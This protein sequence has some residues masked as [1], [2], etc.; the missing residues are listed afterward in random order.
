MVLFQ[1]KKNQWL[2]VSL[3]GV[4]EENGII[5]KILEIKCPH[6]CVNK[7][8]IDIENK[9]SNVPYLHFKENDILLNESHQ[10]YTQCQVQMYATGMSQCDLFVFAPLGSVNIEV[11][12]N[13]NFLKEVIL[14]AELFYFHHYLPVL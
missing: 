3:D 11:F 14:K 5:T 8:V 10:Y 4:V 2:C 13:N 6:S 12:R 9:K 7:P 1:L